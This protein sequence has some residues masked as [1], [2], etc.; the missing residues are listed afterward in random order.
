MSFFPKNAYKTVQ[1]ILPDDRPLFNM[2]QT[3][4]ILC[5]TTP[6]GIELAFDPTGARFGWREILSPLADYISQRVHCV[7]WKIEIDPELEIASSRPPV[8]P[9]SQRGRYLYTEIETSREKF[10][11]RMARKMVKSQ[12]HWLHE[13]HGDR[14][15]DFEDALEA[16]SELFK[17]LRKHS[18]EQVKQLID[19]ELEKT[20]RKEIPYL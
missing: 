4:E 18:V 14:R 12:L 11:Y 17:E 2:L 6:S 5:L 8:N 19:A 7:Q 15:W 13:N 9:Q 20:F 1:R 16:P 3:H 10:Y